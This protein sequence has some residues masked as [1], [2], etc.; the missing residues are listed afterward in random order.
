MVIAQK[1]TEGWL[2]VT[3]SFRFPISPATV[4]VG[5]AAD[6]APVPPA[7]LAFGPISSGG[8]ETNRKWQS[9]RRQI[10]FL[11]LHKIFV[12]L[13]VLMILSPLTP[14]KTLESHRKLSF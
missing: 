6:S 1:V 7:V 13:T 2:P 12:L 4:P 14:N 10:D 8:A 3:V 11:L 9:H 5:V